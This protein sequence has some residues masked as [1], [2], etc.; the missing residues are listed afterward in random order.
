MKTVT[1]ETPYGP[2]NGNFR[3]VQK[4]AKRPLYFI[5]ESAAEAESSNA[6]AV[7]GLAVALG[8]VFVLCM[9][10][11]AAFMGQKK[12]SD[13]TVTNVQPSD[14]ASKGNNSE[15]QLMADAEK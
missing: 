14:D 5:M 11:T 9:V 15:V 3:E 8:I 12:S 13:K 7:I 1:Q 6:G 4:V 2:K 10:I